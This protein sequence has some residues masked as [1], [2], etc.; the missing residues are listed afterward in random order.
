MTRLDI[1]RL[2]KKRPFKGEQITHLQLTGVAGTATKAMYD[3][4][5]TR[6]PVV[7]MAFK[8]PHTR[9]DPATG[10]SFDAVEIEMDLYAANEFLQQ[11]INSVDA[12]MPRR[13]RGAAEHAYGEGA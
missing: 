1:K 13:A 5:G 11:L 4:H 8:V 12:A 3:L 9:E 2:F 6:M 7:V 10:E